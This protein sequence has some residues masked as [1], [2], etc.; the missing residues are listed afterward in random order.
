ML[1]TGEVIGE[2]NRRVDRDGTRSE[3]FAFVK[4]LQRSF[5][6]AGIV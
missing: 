2:Q 4:L 1:D 5:D 6:G 3:D